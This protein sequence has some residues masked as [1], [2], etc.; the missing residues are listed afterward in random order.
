MPRFAAVR[1]RRRSRVYVAST[2]RSS[3]SRAVACSRLPSR[4]FC[5]RGNFSTVGTSHST[6]RY[7][8]PNAGPVRRAPCP[9]ADDDAIIEAAGGRCPPDHPRGKELKTQDLIQR[10]RNAKTLVDEPEAG[11]V[12]VARARPE[13]RGSAAPGAAA[14]HTTAAVALPAVRRPLPHVPNH[15]RQARRIRAVLTDRAGAIRTRP[16]PQPV[17]SGL[18]PGRRTPPLRLRR[19]PIRR[20]RPTAQPRHVLLRVLPAHIHVTG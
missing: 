5:R 4:N 11:G 18:R 10:P 2:K 20:T 9:P 7:I 12:P 19:Q 6:K 17:T 16:S 14:Q 3:T 1:C 8:D 13:E 15:V